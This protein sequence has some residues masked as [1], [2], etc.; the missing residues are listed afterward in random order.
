MLSVQGEEA[1]LLIPRIQK[2]ATDYPWANEYALFPGPNSNTF[3]AW[4]GK[5]LPELGLKMPFR[6]IGSDYVN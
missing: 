6:A 5:Q 2:L 3:P 4:I 1:A